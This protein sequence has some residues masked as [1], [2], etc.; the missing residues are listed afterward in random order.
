M[1]PRLYCID[2]NGLIHWLFHANEQCKENPSHCSVVVQ[3][4]FDN[5]IDKC[6]PTHMMLA[7]D[8]HANWRKQK[9]VEY[10]A[11]RVKRDENIYSQIRELKKSLS[12]KY[13]VVCCEGLEAD[14]V[15]A[16]AVT[17][18]QDEAE[19]VVVSSDK[20]MLQLL[21]SPNVK[22]FDPRK[23]E[24]V[25]VEMF[26]QRFNF[27]PYRFR[28]YLA[29]VGDTS[30]N[31]PG[32]KGWGKVIATQAILQTRSITSLVS[33]GL[34]KEFSNITEKNQ[35]KFVEYYN[36]FKLSYELVSLKTD[37]AT[38]NFV[39]EN[40]RLRRDTGTTREDSPEQDGVGDIGF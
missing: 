29:M 2:M 22:I 21:E 38:D 26:K 20:D 24:V 39:L 15:I 12:E 10:K 23:E 36:D 30:D 3:D 34:K 7:F 8:S 16:C 6:E 18:M 19:V 28:E 9:F 11:N 1:L 35:Q 17:N 4:W 5:F 32:V 25:D 27:E 31:V 13:Q 40:F 37:V 33:T 14:D